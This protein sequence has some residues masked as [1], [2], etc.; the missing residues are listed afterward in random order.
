MTR[1]LMARR[2]YRCTYRIYSMDYVHD[3]HI[4]VEEG[5][6]IQLSMLRAITSPD[7]LKNITIPS[8][9]RHVNEL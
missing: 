4:R 5:V 1:H 8:L 3:C 6:N 2:F 7:F 9:D